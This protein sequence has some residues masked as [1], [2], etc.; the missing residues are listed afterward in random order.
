MFPL[1]EVRVICELSSKILWEFLLITSSAHDAV[2]TNPDT[3]DD[4]GEDEE[5]EIIQHATD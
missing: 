5:V 1:K 3:T 2:Y 4:D